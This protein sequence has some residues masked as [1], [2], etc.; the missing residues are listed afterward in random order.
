MTIDVIFAPTSLM[1]GVAYYNDEDMLLVAIP[2]LQVA[3]YFGD[4]DER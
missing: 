3:I 1:V 4:H 2:L